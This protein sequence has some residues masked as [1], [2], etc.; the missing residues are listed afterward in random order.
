MGHLARHLSGSKL[1]MTKITYDTPTVLN[2]KEQTGEGTGLGQQE[3]VFLLSLVYLAPH[4]QWHLTPLPRTL[5]EAQK[6][7]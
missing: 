4:Q 5:K 6:Q 2:R 1:L 7:R 3:G